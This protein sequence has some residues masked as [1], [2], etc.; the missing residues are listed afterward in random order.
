[1]IADVT[2][3]SAIALRGIVVANGDVGLV[4]IAT[5]VTGAIVVA[6]VIVVAIVGIVIMKKVRKK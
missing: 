2:D 3:M 4:R 1:M 5:I 6:V